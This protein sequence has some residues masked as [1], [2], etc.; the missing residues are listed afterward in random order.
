MKNFLF[1][2]GTEEIPAGY[3]NPALSAMSKILG[4]KLE[5]NRISFGNIKT[6][7]TP[8]RLAILI[9]N[10]DEKQESI[11]SEEIGPPKKVA[12][13]EN[14]EPKIPAH[15]FAE[16][17]G[18][19]VSD[20]YIK[21]TKKGQYL[22]LSIAQDGLKTIDIL[23]NIL[24]DIICEI[25]FPKT[26][27][28]AGFSKSFARPIHSILALFDKE[29]VS[30]NWENLISDKYSFG[31]FF[32]NNQNITINNPDD[33]VKELEKAFVI[34][35]FKKRRELIESQIIDI[36]RKLDG[37]V[38]EDNE[39]LDIVANLVEYPVSVA[40]KFDNKFLDVPREVLITAMR[41]H[42]KYF[43]IINEKNE[44]LPYFIAVNNTKAKNMDIV[45]KGHERVLLARLSDA[46]FFFQVDISQN[47][48]TWV[49]KLKD[50]LFQ[51]RLGSMHDKTLRL[52]NL[53]EF[54]A[55]ELGYENLKNI[56]SRA[57]FLC[58]ADLVCNVVGEFPKLQGIMGRIYADLAQ[59]QDGVGLAIEEHYKPTSS[60]A[61]L[62]ESIQGSLLAIADKIDSICG[63]FVVGLKPTGAADPYALRRQCIGIIQIINNN[64]FS[65]PLNRLISKSLE[66]F[67]DKIKNENIIEE[68][69]EFFTNRMT[70]ILHEHGLSKNVIAAVLSASSIN[71]I[72]V[73][74]RASAL[75]N[76]KNA[77][78]F[79]SIAIA[80]K[81]VSNIVKKADTCSE[82]EIDS[83]LFE[84][85]CERK[86]VDACQLINTNVRLHIKKGLFDDALL[87]MTRLREP[88]DDFFDGILV[89]SDDEKLRNNRLAILSNV[90]KIFEDIADFSKI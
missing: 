75:E 19:K 29:I 28:W 38:L 50:V 47:M 23:Q 66:L 25:P 57:G 42:Q 46:R 13:D 3:I 89:M 74:K 86:L 15:K 61:A 73:F 85:E 44:L 26:M 36:A 40:G 56:V 71:V 20:I 76:L 4:S 65:L 8:R 80:F 11:T 63:C 24:S 54:L 81:R 48:D 1:E 27:K 55:Q 7:G 67:K 59:E 2:I 18:Q 77:P 51:A 49:E 39:L 70:Q 34:V 35:D 6:Y 21:E 88:V 60:K 53:V 83:N 82:L 79:E 32:M 90:K 68:I 45:S 22:C 78:D 12:F 31:H 72:D 87:E 62:P 43:S 17:Y 58:K 33:Y 64:N 9:E 37:K 10:M 16:K 41:E 84:K 14:N 5:K 52:V 69:Q 30:F